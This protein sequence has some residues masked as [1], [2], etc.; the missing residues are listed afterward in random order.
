M[1][2]LNLRNFSNFLILVYAVEEVGFNFKTIGIELLMLYVEL[3]CE[4]TFRE[5]YMAVS[6]IDVTKF[7]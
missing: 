4:R 3:R 1:P 2:V 5:S 6:L 7:A